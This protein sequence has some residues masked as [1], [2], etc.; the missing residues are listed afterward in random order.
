MNSAG[1]YV[2]CSSCEVATTI[3]EHKAYCLEGVGRIAWWPWSRGIECNCPHGEIG[4]TAEDVKAQMF[5]AS[6]LT[7]KTARTY[8]RDLSDT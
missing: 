6:R 8:G 4:L 7:T 3:A 1:F 2:W 5:Q